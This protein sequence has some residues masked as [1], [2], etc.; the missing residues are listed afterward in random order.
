[1]IWMSLLGFAAAAGLL[2]LAGMEVISGIW[3]FI[4]LVAIPILSALLYAG[5]RPP[6]DEHPNVIKTIG[7]GGGC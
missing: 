5:L 6:P 3:A 7:M 1:M 2:A 4:A